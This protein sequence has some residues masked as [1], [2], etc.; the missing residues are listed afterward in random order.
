[1][2][3]DLGAIL[4]FR[5]CTSVRNYIEKFIYLPEKPIKSLKSTKNRIIRPFSTSKCQEIKINSTEN[6]KFSTYRKFS[7]DRN[8]TENFPRTGTENFL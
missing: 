8:G 4:I 2:S 5:S 3:T 6:G 7:A 1:M